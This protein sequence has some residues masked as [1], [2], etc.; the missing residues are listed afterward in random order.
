MP[1]KTWA[2]V[3]FSWDALIFLI[4]AVIF[5]FIWHK[6]ASLI[7]QDKIN[8]FLNEY[9]GKLGGPILFG[10]LFLFLFIAYMLCYIYISQ[11]VSDLF[12]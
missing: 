9:F 8:S 2:E 7:P 1:D 5:L 4:N 10:L 11:I 12:I 3:T 6:A